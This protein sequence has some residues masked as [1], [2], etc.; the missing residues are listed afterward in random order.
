VVNRGQIWWA[1][2]PEP[3]ASEPGYKRPVI[4]IQSDAFNKSRINTVIVVAITSNLRLA[5]APGNVSLTKSRTGLNKQSVA[6][7]SQIITIDKRYLSE[8]IGQL[9]NRIIQQLDEGITLALG[10]RNF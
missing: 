6:N 7:V 8:K 5:D 3:K 10:L 4:I 9:D 1:E 2:L